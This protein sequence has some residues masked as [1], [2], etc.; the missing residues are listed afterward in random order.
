MATRVRIRVTHQLNHLVDGELFWDYMDTPCCHPEI[1]RLG[2]I[3]GLEIR[4][5][6]INS[7]SRK[8]KTQAKTQKSS[9]KFRK[10]KQKTKGLG[11][12]L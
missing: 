10:L 5:F 1:A 9:K 2:L 8:P 6:E 7:N 12:F 4:H 11:K 3:P